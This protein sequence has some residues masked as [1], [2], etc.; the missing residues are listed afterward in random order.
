M[1]PS[2]LVNPANPFRSRSSAVLSF[3][4][5]HGWFPDGDKDNVR[6]LDN[7]ESSIVLIDDN[8][9][10]IHSTGT[11]IY[12]RDDTARRIIVEAYIDNDR[13]LASSNMAELV[14]KSR[15]CKSI[16][17][18]LSNNVVG[19][20]PVFHDDCDGA[21]EICNRK[22]GY[23]MNFFSRNIDMIPS[24]IEKHV[25][26]KD[27]KL[28][29]NHVGKIENLEKLVN[30]K[31]LDVSLNQIGKLEGLNNLVNLEW[32]YLRDNQIGKLEG[33]DALA[34]LKELNVGDNQIGKLE[35]LDTLAN[36]EWLYLRDNQIG[37]LEGI[38]TLVKLKNLDV[39]RNNIK[40][41]ECRDFKLKHLDI[42]VRC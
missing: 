29:D 1:N 32:L 40:F 15:H 38:D 20:I 12:L 30:L 39:S 16:N 7:V 19:M 13:D 8:V 5:R 24:C 42:N 6:F 10:E 37:K 28:Y 3:H 17:G 33:L 26:V 21:H 23:E 41:D 34:N 35:N 11:P 36:L 31:G 18:K 2:R 14:S 4:A 27:L 9:P 25:G 22:T